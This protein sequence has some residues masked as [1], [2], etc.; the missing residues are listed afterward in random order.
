MRHRTPQCASRAQLGR[1]PLTSG[2]QRPAR[3][4][5]LACRTASL[6]FGGRNG[7][8]GARHSAV[9]GFQTGHYHQG[10]VAGTIGTVA[11]VVLIALHA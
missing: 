5:S 3:T 10:R 8:A 2:A 9:A 4:A 11:G 7:R 1:K 6:T